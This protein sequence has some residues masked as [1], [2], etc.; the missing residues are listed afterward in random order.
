VVRPEDLEEEATP[1]ESAL[2]WLRFVGELVIV[3]AAGVGIYFLFNVL[4]EN[5][6]YVAVLLAPF[7]VTALVG[8]VA[9][10]RRRMGHE[11][12]GPK[13]LVVLVFAG[14]LLTIVP[15]A[16]LLNRA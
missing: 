2:A 3:L 11:P 7:A 14:T 13:L 6:P 10:W 16:Q 15:A 1:R 5:L 4:W 8:G 12:V 9:F